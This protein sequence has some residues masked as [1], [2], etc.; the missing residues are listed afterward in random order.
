MNTRISI[1]VLLICTTFLLQGCN[2]VVQQQNVTVLPDSNNKMESQK[3]NEDELLYGKYPEPILK[4]IGKCN[5][6]NKDYKTLTK[7]DLNNIKTLTIDARNRDYGFDATKEYDFSILQ[8]MPDLI[9]LDITDIKIKDYSIFANLNKLQTLVLGLLDDNTALYLKYLTKL[10]SLWI[11]NSSISNIE[12]VAN[13]KQIERFCLINCP[14]VKD[15]SML[16]SLCYVNYLQL[17][18]MGIDNDSISTLPNTLDLL[19]ELDLSNNNIKDLSPN[20]PSLPNLNILTLSCNPLEKI[21]VPTEKLPEISFLILDNTQI[22][23][24]NNIDVLESLSAISIKS[25]PVKYIAPLK[26]FKNLRYIYLDKSNIKDLHIFNNT[27]VTIYEI[28]N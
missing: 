21:S 25:T 14:N 12:F 2:A 16:K 8:Y 1:V 10:K 13:L 27:N 20:F 5:S 18:G 4:A 19:H 3:S 24:L 22:N 6:I 7:K 26:K 17:N 9:D 23:D 28:L 15:F 11:C